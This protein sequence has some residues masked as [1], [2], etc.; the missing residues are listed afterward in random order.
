MPQQFPIPKK[1][2]L[3]TAWSCGPRTSQWA[4]LWTR[5]LSYALPALQE[6]S[7]AADSRTPSAK[8]AREDD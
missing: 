1:F 2:D 3:S 7:T 4:S 5:L 8:E 6:E